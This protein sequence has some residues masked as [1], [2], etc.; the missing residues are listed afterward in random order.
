MTYCILTYPFTKGQEFSDILFEL[1]QEDKGCRNN[2]GVLSPTPFDNK[3]FGEPP[4]NFVYINGTIYRSDISDGK[5]F[6][7]KIMASPNHL[8]LFYPFNDQFEYKNIVDYICSTQSS[9]IVFKFK[10]PLKQYLHIYRGISGKHNKTIWR[11]DVSNRVLTMLTVE[12]PEKINTEIQTIIFV[13][14]FI[15]NGGNKA[16]LAKLLGIGITNSESDN[17]LH[18]DEVTEDLFMNKDVWLSKKQEIINKLLDS[19]YKDVIIQQ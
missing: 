19:T 5:S 1:L 17:E 16:A 13:E 6:L 8:L 9:S 12:S 4:E 2:L 14:D 15:A 7:K 3:Y 10:D 18:Y 11:E